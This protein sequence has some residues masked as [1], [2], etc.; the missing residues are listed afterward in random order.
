M[1]QKH[2]VFDLDGTLVN[3]AAIVSSILNSLRTD[4]GLPP[5]PIQSFIPWLSLGGDALVSNA[6]EIPIDHVS[7]FTK[8]FRQVYFEQQTPLESI[9]PGVFETLELL[10]A[11]NISLS[12]CTNKPRHLAEKVLKETRLGD[13]FSFL[14]AGGDFPTNKPD[15]QNLLAC[16]R[17]KSLISAESFFV[18]DST[19]DQTTANACNVNFIFHTNGYDDGVD[20]QSSYA[21]FANYSHFPQLFV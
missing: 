15:P 9:Y 3:S 20:K 2:V 16:F 5:V 13:F 14:S 1:N 8:T 18:G 12:I 7:P 11:N 10:T 19:V 21:C 17:F 4:L 6:L